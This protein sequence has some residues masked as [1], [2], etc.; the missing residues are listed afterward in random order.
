MNTA[1][2][3]FF[4]VATLALA[5]ALTA[6]PVLAFDMRAS[7]T[8]TVSSG[9]AVDEDL[10][11][12]G[13]T[14]GINGTVNAD[15][16]AAGQTVT[17]GGTVANGVMVAGQTVLVNAN[18]GHGVRAAGT[19]V[20][21]GGAIG[22]D[23]LVASN[24][25]VISDTAVI[26][27]DLAFGANTALIRG[28]VDGNVIGG[29]EKLVIEGEIGGDVNVQVGTLE[30]KPGATIAGNLTYTGSTESTV[31]AGAVK[32]TVTFT[33]RVDKEAKAEVSRGLGA[34]APLAFFAGLT[35]KFIAYLMAFITGLV[36]ILLAPK[37]MAGASSAIRTDT[38]PVAGW[39][40]IALFATPLAAIVACITIV[41][42]PL[43]II[44][45]LLWGIL[46]YL[47]QLPVGLVIGHL[48]LG[49]HKPLEGKGFMIGSLAL[50]LLL[51]ALV[52]IIPFVGFF[53]S[54]ST[55]LFGFGAFVVVGRNWM[56]ARRSGEEFPTF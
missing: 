48:I 40:A 50:G 35:W 2:R 6:A 55:A 32:G 52:R 31:I 53:V 20:N 44:T 30:L 19:T 1:K 54:L 51:I 10:Y 56:R 39:G 46:L 5:L 24:D 3:A 17:I 7:D 41:G 29:A 37:C 4:V 8:V 11:L 45:M 49:R 33:E 14:L 18:V 25:L 47:S 43:G 16:F 9:E 34:L 38:G 21:I 26:T 13:R 23:L 28:K 15:V 12:A 27:G 36:L 42:M 22:R